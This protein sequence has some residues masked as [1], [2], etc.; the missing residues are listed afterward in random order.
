LVEYSLI[1]WEDY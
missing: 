1:Y